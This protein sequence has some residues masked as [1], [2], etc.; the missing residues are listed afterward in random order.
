V[1]L[2]QIFA[3][4]FLKIYGKMI[5]GSS[6]NTLLYLQLISNSIMDYKKG[7]LYYYK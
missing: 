4:T 3:N 5:S 1:N 7:N 6:R 2:L